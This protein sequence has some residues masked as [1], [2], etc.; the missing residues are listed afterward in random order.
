MVEAS[1]K[2]NRSEYR[3]GFK[4]RVAVRLL[5]SASLTGSRL[6]KPALAWNDG[7]GTEHG[8]QTDMGLHSRDYA[9]DAH[10]GGGGFFS[11]TGGGVTKK[12]VIGTI[13]VF[14]LQL[15]TRS[16]GASTNL[17]TKY[18][19]VSFEAVTSYG[20]I[21]RVLTYAFC[22]SDQYIFHIVFN[23]YALWWAGREVESLYGSKE[24]LWFYLVAAIFSG[25]C[26]LLVALVFGVGRTAT[27]TGASGAV[28]AVFMVYARHY[29]RRKIH[30]MGILPVEARWL[31]LILVGLDVLPLLA[32]ISGGSGKSGVA[33]ACHLGGALFGWIYFSRQ[34]RLSSLVNGVGLGNFRTRQKVRKSKLKI[35]NPPE[36]QSGSAT[37]PGVSGE[38]VDAILA[39][40]S[41]EGEDSL[42]DREREIL[43]EASRQYKAKQ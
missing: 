3:S 38:Q 15:L 31:L 33:H 41:A 19:A 12:I 35:F 37:Q 27:M 32:E 1:G 42:T 20:Q 24:F 17:V 9:R 6:L 4:T 11:T 25:V 34:L 26:Y 7:A 18:L 14:V 30:M 5:R 43:K 13:I 10:S 8:F 36:Q 2:E 21:W 40:I 29:P 28:L 39:K 23:M 16:P 22:H